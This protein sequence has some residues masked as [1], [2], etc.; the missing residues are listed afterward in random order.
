M[1]N[2]Y[3]KAFTL[4]ELLIVIALLGTLAVGMLAA[5][6]PF[7][8][9]KKGTDTGVRNTVT[10]FHEAVIRYYAIKNRMPWCTGIDD[11]T[12]RCSTFRDG[13]TNPDGTLLSSLT[14]T[15]NE[16]VGTGEL[17]SSFSSLAKDQLSK[18]YVTGTNEPPTIIVCFKPVSKSFQKDPNTVYD[19]KGV[20]QTSG[21]KSQG[22]GNS[23]QDCY[24]CI[25]DVTTTSGG[26][27][28]TNTPTPTP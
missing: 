8:Q 6:D 14:N 7:E 3:Q 25:G 16:I 23:G 20:K 28:T 2:I 11:Q 21:C 5:L 1:K 24:W 27:G 18:I 13:D 9:L 15:I 4:I 19:N 26:G 22:T 10:E 17:K 12:G